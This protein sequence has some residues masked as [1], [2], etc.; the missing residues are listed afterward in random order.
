[1]DEI[2]IGAEIVFNITGN[3]NIGYAKGE[4]YIGTVL[5]KDHRSRLYVRTIGMPRA[6][7]DERDVEWVI[8]PDGDFD[9][10]E[11]IP[12]PMARELYKLMG[13][14]VYT[15]GRSYES[16]NGYIVYECMMMD[17][18]LRYNVMYALHDHG[19][20]I[21]HIDSYSWW[22]TNERL[23]SEVTYTEGDI[24]IIVHEC[25]EDYVDNVRFGEEFYKNKDI[26]IHVPE[27]AV[28]K[29]GPSAGVTMFTSVM[30]ALTGNPIRKDVAMTGEITLRGKVLPVGGIKEKVLAAHRAG[31][32]TILLPR[33]NEA[34]IEEI[35]QSVRKQL[36]FHLLDK[37]KEALEYAM[38]KDSE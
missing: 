6:C 13:R 38:V 15:F 22:M 4:K 20:E 33:E 11:A 2:K 19:F 17:R 16:I 34:D 25:M 24:H 21:R 37:A 18:D 9:M 30:S 29:D 3:H 7:I 31:I 26:H 10:D 14:Y 1:M 36:T 32:R 28:P 35:P 27:G 23:M 8:D 5:S 12:N